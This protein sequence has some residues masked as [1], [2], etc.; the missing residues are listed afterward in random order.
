MAQYNRYPK[1][2][3]QI[4]AES[5]AL[6]ANATPVILTNTATIDAAESGTIWVRVF[7]SDTTVEIANPATITFVPVVGTTTTEVATWTG[8]G[9]RLPGCM[10][11]AISASAS[12]VIEWAAGALICEFAI[13]MSQI[14][15]LNTGTT[16]HMYLAVYAVAVSNESADNIEAYLYIE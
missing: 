16:K 9:D 12:S 14:R 8:G 3:D 2:A 6:P 15:S 10:V 11:S 13:P 7:A 5:Y 4:L 1:P